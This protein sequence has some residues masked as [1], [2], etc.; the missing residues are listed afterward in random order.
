MACRFIFNC[1]VVWCL[2]PTLFQ[3]VLTGRR[4]AC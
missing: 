2:H 1:F 3:L 4:G